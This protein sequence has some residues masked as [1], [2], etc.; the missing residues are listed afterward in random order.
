MRDQ[1]TESK[2]VEELN[3]ISDDVDTAIKCFY[4]Y[5]EI[6]NY[7]AEDQRIYR[8]INKEP[9]FWKINLYSLQTAFFIALARIFD[10][11]KDAHS[12]HKLLTATVAHPEFFSKEA[13]GARRT[14]GGP[15]PEW[16]DTYLSDIFEPQV[17][18]LR[19][20]KKS[21]SMHRTSYNLAY[22]DIR[23]FVFAHRIYSDKEQIT[24]LFSKTLPVEVDKM[25]YN[26]RDLLDAVRDLFVNGRRPELGSRTFDYR[27][28]I[29]NGV[30]STLS[31]LLSAK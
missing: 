27:N 3:L 25:L 11:G 16:L 30:R 10:D 26:L 2:Y 18:D 17:A 15:K 9:E 12:I 13:L 19:A 23:N 5:I 24:A 22:A 20:L 28:R 8:A 6:H 14:A 1:M 31:E 4:T 21:L 29:K 7:A